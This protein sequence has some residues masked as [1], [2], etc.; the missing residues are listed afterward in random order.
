MT[1]SFSKISSF[2]SIFWISRFTEARKM[3]KNLLSV[4]LGLAVLFAYT[5]CLNPVNFDETQLPTLDITGSLDT[6]DVT[7]A[8]TYIVNLS[9]SLNFTEV[10]VTQNLNPALATN[11]VPYLVSKFPN[12]KNAQGNWK[13]V[14][15]RYIQ[16]SD[17][18]YEVGLNIINGNTETPSFFRTTDLYATQSKGIYYIWLYRT[19]DQSYIDSQIAAGVPPEFADV[20]VI[21]PQDPNLPPLL[22][23][24]SD[25]DTQNIEV[26]IGSSNNADIVA[27]LQKISNTLVNGFVKAEPPS[28]DDE[29][30]SVPP[31]IS[32]H[33]RSEMGTFIVVNLSRTMNIDS[34]AFK[35]EEGI[36]VYSNVY[37][38]ISPSPGTPAVAAQDRNAIAL[39]NGTY[40]ITAAYGGAKTTS[41]KRGVLL[42]SNDPQTVREHYIYFYKAKNGS[43]EL[44]ID[45]PIT[46]DIDPSD[47]L[48]PSEYGAGRVRIVNRT[49]NALVDSISITSK[50]HPERGL[51]AKNYTGFIPARPIGYDVGEVDFTGTPTF[52]IDGYFV[53]NVSLLTAEDIVMV[54]RLVFLNNSIAEIII[55]PND[56]VLSNVPGSKITVTNATTTESVINKIE[57][58]NVAQPAE[59]ADVTLAIANGNAYSFNVV[60]TPGMPIMEG[61]S[62]KAKLT[63]TV[64]KQ[65]TGKYTIDG[66]EVENP[67]ITNTGVIEKDFSPDNSLYGKNGPGSHERFITLD[68]AN[69]TSIIPTTPPV[70]PAFVPVSDVIILNGEAQPNGDV[71]F[72]AKD[73]A[74]RQLSWKV[75]PEEATNKDGYW[76]LGELDLNVLMGH[77]SLTKNGLLKVKSSWSYDYLYVAFII[78]N[79]IAEGARSPKINQLSK[80]QYL[81]FDETKDFVKVFKLLTPPPGVVTPPTPPANQVTLL[82]NYIGNGAGSGD[83]WSVN[84]IEVYKRPTTIYNN[85][86]GGS[87]LYGN[88]VDDAGYL[89]YGSVATGRTG[90][91][92]QANPYDDLNLYWGG[93]TEG[94]VT[95]N[96]PPSEQLQGVPSR[97]AYSHE[98]QPSFLDSIPVQAGSG[99]NS[100][101]SGTW[102]AGNSS[103]NK[104]NRAGEKYGLT[105]PTD[106]GKL[107]IRLR[108]DHH[109]AAVGYWWKAVY[110]QE[111]FVFDPATNYKKENGAVIIDVDLYNTPYMQYRK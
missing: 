78:E 40:A 39:K 81:L 15:A 43:Y 6:R 31:V 42:P 11:E 3:K 65:L 9:K 34:V 60:S 55:E 25:E 30:G 74:E 93:T 7:A 58:F 77:Y 53:A 102:L 37:T 90:W 68:E 52:P 76:T 33:N 20:L 92:W 41:P 89:R 57:I 24:P 66:N 36:G 108:M 49:T 50:D 83:K 105:V 48:P 29:N 95:S 56:A 17:I 111:W 109:D 54:T 14:K 104:L 28:A 35:Q 63:V 72:F 13:N 94:W 88:P 67:L 87:P 8:S 1:R 91:H 19:K 18:E 79:G 110:L 73:G 97:S 10:T 2:G 70:A 16:A 46:E 27:V 103:D 47:V 69:I 26:N 32:P 99:R 82:L 23:A 71:K 22:P 51:M 21:S 101:I 100:I 44:S 38:I 98:I 107:W 62:Y 84:L 86:G 80:M 4:C 75:I 5:T 85:T 96:P 64:T 45:R 106:Q 59:H 12:T 61:Y